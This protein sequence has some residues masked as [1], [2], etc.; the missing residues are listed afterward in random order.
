MTRMSELELLNAIAQGKTTFDRVEFPDLETID[1]EL[2]TLAEV[3]YVGRVVRAVYTTAGGRCLMRIDV[4]GGLPPQG[5]LRRRRLL[6]QT[7]FES[8]S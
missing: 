1:I 2:R 7:V 8:V 5:E 6:T 3:G 4:L